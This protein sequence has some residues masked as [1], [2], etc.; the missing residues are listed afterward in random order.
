MDGNGEGEGGG[1]GE[2]EAA[3]FKI[4]EIGQR[5]PSDPNCPVGLG[6]CCNCYGVTPGGTHQIEDSDDKVASLKEVCR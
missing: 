4:L 6:S 2:G 5:D 3:A 1:G